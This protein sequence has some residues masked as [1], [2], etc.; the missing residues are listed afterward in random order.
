MILSRSSQYGLE[1]ILYLVSHPTEKY[2][3]LNEIAR[4]NNLSFYFLS[5]ITQALVQ[6]GILRT[7]RGPRGGVILAVS[8]KELTLFD[9]INAIDGNALFNKCILRLQTCDE[10]NPCPIHPLCSV[11]R[12]DIQNIFMNTTMDKIKE[13]DLPVLSDLSVL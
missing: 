7:Y 12:K 5:K 10:S 1:L 3:P 4:K 11:L 2:I 6:N 13:G 9:V 8:S